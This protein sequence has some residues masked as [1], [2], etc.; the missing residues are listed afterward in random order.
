MAG[1]ARLA[2]LLMACVAQPAAAG[3][4]CRVPLAEWQPREALQAKLVAQGLTVLSIRTDDGCYK[5]QARNAAGEQLSGKYNPRSLQPVNEDDD[6]ESEE[7][8]E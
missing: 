7:D 4:H 3:S 5:V 1:R 2:L 8:G 6:G